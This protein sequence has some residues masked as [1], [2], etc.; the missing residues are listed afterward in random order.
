MKH[1]WGFRTTKGIGNKFSE[2]FEVYGKP[3]LKDNL[4]YGGQ[5]FD[6]ANIQNSSMNGFPVITGNPRI[7][8]SHISGL[9]KVSGIAMIYYSVLSESAV[10]ADRGFVLSSEVRDSARVVEKARISDVILCE[11]AV[12]SGDAQ[13]LGT[14]RE[15]LWIGGNTFINTGVWSK[16]PLTFDCESGFTVTESIYGYVS[17]GCITNRISKFLSSGE[18]YLKIL[19]F[20]E[21]D[22]DEI[23]EYV[24][25]IRD[26]QLD[27]AWLYA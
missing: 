9:S 17:V 22:A 3:F 2:E 1:E 14:E 20:T 8:S 10:V 6:T 19:G 23:R 7:L 21:R 25:Y 11:G 16:A 13:V 15:P 12:I 26:Y 24:K 5:V 18:R 4:L 27:E